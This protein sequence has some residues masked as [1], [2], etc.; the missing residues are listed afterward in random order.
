MITGLRF[1]VRP[2]IVYTLVIPGA[3]RSHVYQRQI[4]QSQQERVPA[5]KIGFDDDDI[6]IIKSRHFSI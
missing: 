6:I 2:N 4:W 5:F 3:R 1:E